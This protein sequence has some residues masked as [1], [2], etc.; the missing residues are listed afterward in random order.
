MIS[1]RTFASAVKTGLIIFSM[2]LF[3]V[4][5]FPQ[6]STTSDSASNDIEKIAAHTYRLGSIVLNSEKRVITVPGKVNLEKGIVEVIACAPGGKVHESLFVL[7]VVPY[8]LQ[9]ALLL[10]GLKYEGGLEVQGDSAAPRGDSV[11]V[12]VEWTMGKKQFRMRAEDLVWDLARNAP[13]EHT[14]FVFSG[15]KM[16]DGKFMADVEKSLITTYHDPF[17]ILDNPLSTG[18]NDELYKVN[19]SQIPPKGTPITITIQPVH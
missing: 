19:E 17:T 2:L 4:T 18:A 9:V 3:P 14:P 10:L 7:D 11:N 15:S 8:H 12:W 1:S 16:M 13:M 5:A 6:E